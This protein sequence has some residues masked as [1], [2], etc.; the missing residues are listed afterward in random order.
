[1]VAIEAMIYIVGYN[2]SFD[3]G[4]PGHL[5]AHPQHLQLWNATR[6]TCLPLCLD[7]TLAVI[8]LN[9]L[10]EVIPGGFISNG[11]ASATDAT[12]NA[13]SLVGIFDV[14]VALDRKVGTT[15]RRGNHHR[16]GKNKE[17]FYPCLAISATV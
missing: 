4:G 10:R 12:A 5:V 15:K 7:T 13:L 14:F 8:L 2:V 16:Q 6:T 17:P 1:M 11:L 9:I 3:N